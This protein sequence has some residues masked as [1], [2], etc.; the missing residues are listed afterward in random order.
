MSKFVFSYYLG[1]GVF[2]NKNYQP[3]S[4]I[5][6]YPGELISEKEAELREE[7]YNELQK[8]CFLYFFKEGEKTLW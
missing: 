3:D 2:A 5:L 6:E 4:F 7:K 8:G 1:H